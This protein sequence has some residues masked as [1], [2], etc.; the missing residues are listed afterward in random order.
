MNDLSPAQ[1]RHE[2]QRIIQRK[3]RRNRRLLFL[4]VI[5]VTSL[6]LFLGGCSKPVKATQL[7]DGTQRVKITVSHGYSPSQIEAEAGKPLKIEFYRDEDPNVHS[8]TQDVT[9]P[10]ENVN[11]HLPVHESQIVEIKPPQGKGE[12]AFQCGMGM[13]KGKISFQ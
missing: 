11:L 1:R 5:G 12:V 13:Q 7:P 4:S 8:C 10:S 6:S 3:H 9:V 2:K